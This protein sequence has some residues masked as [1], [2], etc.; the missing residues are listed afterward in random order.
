MDRFP[1][2]TACAAMPNYLFVCYRVR[3]L[4]MPNE[5]SL[6]AQCCDCRATVWAP[7][8][9]DFSREVVWVCEPCAPR[10]EGAHV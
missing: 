9:I 8:K 7:I 4:A 5:P 10:E 6:M 1:D 3:D 2:R